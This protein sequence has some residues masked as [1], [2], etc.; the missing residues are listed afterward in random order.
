[1][2][3]RILK[4]PVQVHFMHGTL[5]EAAA[6]KCLDGRTAIR[7]RGLSVSPHLTRGV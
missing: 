7:D 3:M 2:G 5:K 1:M 4:T 6:I